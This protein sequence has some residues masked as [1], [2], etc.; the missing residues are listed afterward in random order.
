MLRGTPAHVADPYFEGFD[1]RISAYVCGVISYAPKGEE[2]RSKS[3][4]VLSS[5]VSPIEA[6]A[7]EWGVLRQLCAPSSAPRP[8]IQMI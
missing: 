6:V 4:K 3:G 2:K 7:S 8:G 5:A 1:Q